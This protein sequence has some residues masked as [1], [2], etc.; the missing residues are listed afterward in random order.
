MGTGTDGSECYLSASSASG[1]ITVLK[2]V[3]LPIARKKYIFF[4]EPE[5]I[6]IGMDEVV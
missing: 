4:S 5:M 1:K 6:S 3:P 2:Y